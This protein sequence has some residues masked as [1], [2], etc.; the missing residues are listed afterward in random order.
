MK[1]KKVITTIGVV[2][3]GLS[4][5]SLTSHTA[6]AAEVDTDTVTFNVKNNASVKLNSVLE[7]KFFYNGRRN[8]FLNPDKGGTTY[9]WDT[10]GGTY[11]DPRQLYSKGVH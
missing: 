1:L 4:A 8:Y 3:L 5:L 7:S 6:S 2:A 11:R 9:L 10:P